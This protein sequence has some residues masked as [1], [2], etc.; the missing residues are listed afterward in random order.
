LSYRCSTLQCKYT[1]IYFEPP[2]VLAFIFNVF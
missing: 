2:N 1:T